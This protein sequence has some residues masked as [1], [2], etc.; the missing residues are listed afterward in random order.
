MFSAAALLNVYTAN[1]LLIDVKRLTKGIPLT[2]ESMASDTYG[3][4]CKELLRWSLLVLLFGFVCG[5]LVA[6]APVR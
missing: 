4:W 3:R 1:M 6:A 5:N 2:F